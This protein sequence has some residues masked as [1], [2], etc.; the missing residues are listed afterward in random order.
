LRQSGDGLPHLFPTDDCHT[1]PELA[2]VIDA[3]SRLDEPTRQ[4]IL[5]LIRNSLKA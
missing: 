2:E 3:W 1:A 4:A 5:T